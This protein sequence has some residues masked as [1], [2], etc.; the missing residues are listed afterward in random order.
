MT[1]APHPL[2][3]AVIRHKLQAVAEEMVETMTQTCFSPILNQNQD[4]SAVVL[5]AAGQTL[6]QAER[7]PI[8]MGAMPWAIRA[9]AEA[10]DG[11][12]AKDDVLMANDPYWGGSHLPDITLALPVFADGALRLWVALRAHQG[13][14]GGLSA[15]G[16]SAG[17]TEIWHEGIRIPPVKLVEGGRLRADLLRMVAANSRKPDDLHGDVMAQL[18]AVTVGSKRLDGLFARYGAAEVGR[19]A[20]AILDGGE[21]VMRREIRRWRDGAYEG[22]SWLEP[23]RE[24]DPL[25]PIRARVTLRHGSALVDLRDCPDQVPSF[26]NSPIANTRA[27]VNVAFLYLSEDA[28]VLN[29][30]S[31]RAI[32]I[33]TRPGSIVDPVLPAPVVACTSLTSAAL[34]EA[35]M[36]ALE[37]AAPDVAVAGF[38]RRF[39]FA[40]AG[41]DRQGRPYIWHYFLN[42]GGAGANA[43]SD[44]WTNLGGVHNPGGSPSP[45]VERTEAGYPLLIE[46]YA[47]RPDSGGAGLRCG[48]PGGV[49]RMRYEGAAPAV[50]NAAGEG[51][52]VRPRGILGGEDGLGHAYSLERADG[53]VVPIGPRD[54]GVVV[55]PGDVV[56]CL[57]AGGGGY[58]PPEQRPADL[59]ARDH[60]WGYRSAP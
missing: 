16:Y 59:A 10:F 38:T 5:D 33:L 41:D 15:G 51:V 25:I 20:D 23:G 17:A 13:D 2:T 22:V 14:I 34:I 52:V 60:D 35:V 42:R 26:L 56:V 37:Q 8:H 57:S 7:V 29:E 31:A 12:I 18:A 32:E 27:A 54:A 39:R 49:L 21:A 53:T 58:G 43:R 4:F 30:G 40:L 28:Q 47:L 19:C 3:L 48:G 50:L 11:D 55:R 46:E 1:A 6:A 45:S 44:G 9:M 36:A 24:G